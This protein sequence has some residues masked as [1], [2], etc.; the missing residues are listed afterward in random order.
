KGR[1]IE[2]A[3]VETVFPSLASNIGGTYLKPGRAVARTGNRHGGLA[4]SPYNVYACKDGYFSIICQSEGHW[5][6]LLK[7][8]GRV[9]L[10]DDARFTNN[11]ARVKHMTET[12]ALVESWASSLTREE[13]FQLTQEHRVPSAPVRDLNEVMANKH[14]HERGMLEEIDHPKLGRVIVPNSPL[15]YRGT[16]Q[17]KSTPSPELGQHN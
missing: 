5:R 14:M 9:D 8:M 1:M 15:R 2:V 6:S 7:A 3:M 12:D 13:I 17:M 11:A 16:P 4:V 10:V